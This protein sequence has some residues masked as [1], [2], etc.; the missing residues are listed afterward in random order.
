MQGGPT[1]Q[2]ICSRHALD[3]DINASFALDSEPCDENPLNMLLQVANKPEGPILTKMPP[4]I[5]P[6]LEPVQV[7]DAAQSHSEW[8]IDDFEAP[9]N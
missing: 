5:P 9:T 1:L 4:N 2:R 6:Y 3:E 7:S 8:S